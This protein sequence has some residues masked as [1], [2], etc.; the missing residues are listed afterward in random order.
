MGIKN[1]VL[2]EKGENEQLEKFING[3]KVTL[4]ISYLMAD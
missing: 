3:H 2:P 1:R 4:I